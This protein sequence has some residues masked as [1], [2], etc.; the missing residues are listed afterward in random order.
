MNLVEFLTA[1]GILGVISI[2]IVKA[3]NLTRQGKFYSID[4]AIILFVASLLF[5]FL[6]MIGGLTMY[7]IATASYLKLTALLVLTTFFLTIAEI[8]IHLSKTAI[9]PMMPLRR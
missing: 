7:S 2:F 8:I 3:Y 9:R 6:V 5:Y 1:C 4:K